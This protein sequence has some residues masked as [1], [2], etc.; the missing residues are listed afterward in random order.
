VFYKENRATYE[1]DL[2]NQINAVKAKKGPTPLDRIL[3]GDKTWTIA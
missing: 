3:S 2:I 1:D